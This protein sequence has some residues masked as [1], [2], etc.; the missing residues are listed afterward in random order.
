M[1]FRAHGMCRFHPRKMFEFSKSSLTMLMGDPLGNSKLKDVSGSHHFVKH[2]S[3][4]KLTQI[5]VH[6]P[7]FFSSSQ[8]WRVTSLV[9]LGNLHNQVLLNLRFLF[10]VRTLEY[11]I[12]A[13][14]LSLPQ[15]RGHF[16]QRCISCFRRR[17][18]WK[19]VGSQ[20]KEPN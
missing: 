13:K 9:K 2:G 6:C 11:E 16:V 1:G 4:T 7:A 10:T 20:K 3:P 18:Q 12:H 5:T 15:N 17:R 14:C 19:V 8:C